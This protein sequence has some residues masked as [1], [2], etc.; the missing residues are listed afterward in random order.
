MHTWV[1][2]KLKALDA[3]KLRRKL[4]LPQ[5]I[6]RVCQQQGPRTRTRRGQS[7]FGTRVSTADDDDIKLFGIGDHGGDPQ[8]FRPGSIDRV[9]AAKN[10]SF[11]P[12]RGRWRIWQASMPKR[13]RP[14]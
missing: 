6:D 11:R 10:G 1:E 13:E 12:C 3:Q 14:R 4:D 2:K 8:E 5:G 7:C 9:P